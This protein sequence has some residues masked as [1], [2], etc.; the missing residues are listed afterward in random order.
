LPTAVGNTN[1]YS[2]T[3]TGT[4]TVTVATTG[5]Q[6]INGSTT[7]TLPV[8]NMSLDFISTGTNWVVE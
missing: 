8:Q 4:N 6:T 1:R 5:A 7:A 3:N 2:V